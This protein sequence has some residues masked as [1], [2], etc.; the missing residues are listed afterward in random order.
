M[1]QPEIEAHPQVHT[2]P[3][4]V[5]ARPDRSLPPGYMPPEALPRGYHPPTRPDLQVSGALARQTRRT[6][7]THGQFLTLAL[8]LAVCV[9]LIVFVAS[10]LF[11][12]SGGTL[13]VSTAP[14]A[15]V[16]VYFTA[17]SH[18]DYAHAF[19]LLSAH[20]QAGETRSAFVQR[21]QQIDLV[22]GFVVTFTLAS[23]QIQ[24]AKATS[25]VTVQ[26][27]GASITIETVQLVQSGGKWYIDAI[28]T[29]AGSTSPT[30]TP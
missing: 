18:Q 8:V 16:R 21:N 12:A 10:L 3:R 5:V 20:A 23:T 1:S 22:G 11:G 19:D 26:R 25:M 4:R 29:R 9:G 7:L 24:G 30:T 27:Q 14:D 28:T 15:T 6:A 17:V 2:P 13:T